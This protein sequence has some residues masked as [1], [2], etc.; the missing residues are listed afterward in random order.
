M[1]LHE[2]LHFFTVHWI[3][4]T[5]WSALSWKYNGACYWSSE[6]VIKALLG[7]WA[8]SKWPDSQISQHWKSQ[9][10]LGE[11][12]VSNVF[13]GKSMVYL[14]VAR[15]HQILLWEVNWFGSLKKV[16]GPLVWLE[17][18]WSG[19]DALCFCFSNLHF[20]VF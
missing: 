17:S 5:V 6:V 19:F 20:S 3:Y 13:W 15:A 2:G 9:Q 14:S 16:R 10:A 18:P 12:Q 4:A 7:K 11:I 1:I 8:T